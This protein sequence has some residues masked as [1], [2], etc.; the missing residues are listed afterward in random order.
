MPVSGISPAS[1]V[2]ESC[3]ALTDPFEVTVVVTAQSA[4][5]P[6]PKRTS[7]PSIDPVDWSTPKRA[8][9]GLPPAS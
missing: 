9:A 8:I 6:A 1:G 5:R 2:S 7:L 3:I 4:E